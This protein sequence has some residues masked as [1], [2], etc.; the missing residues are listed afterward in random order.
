MYNLIYE[1]QKLKGWP[2]LA[3]E[4]SSVC[5]YL[6]IENCNQTN[7]YKHDYK[8]LLI[9]ACHTKNDEQLRM[10][11]QGKCARIEYGRKE[12]IQKKNIFHVRLQFRARFGLTAFA[13]NYSH[14]RR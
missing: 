2:G 4:T 11:A 3:E 9:Q 6:Q 5:Q 7:I 1:E 13:G 8:K 14:D 10:M 12:Y